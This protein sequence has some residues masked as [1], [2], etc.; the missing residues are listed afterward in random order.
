MIV[1]TPFGV[2]CFGWEIGFRHNPVVLTM[3]QIRA[4]VGEFGFSPIIKSRLVALPAKCSGQGR[5]FGRFLWNGHYRRER[6]G[7]KAAQE[8]NQALFAPVATGVVVGK[9][10]PFVAQLI[11]IGRGTSPPAQPRYH[12]GSQTFPHNQQ[13]V[14]P[15]LSKYP[16]VGFGEVNL[17]NRLLCRVFFV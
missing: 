9:K 3:I 8:C 2:P 11:K 14:G 7:R 17:L 16:T 4:N 10:Q 13:H 15:G 12:F 1:G 5:Q 6:L